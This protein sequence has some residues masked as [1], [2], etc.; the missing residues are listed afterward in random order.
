MG[1]L[2]TLAQ[3]YIMT[4]TNQNL[5][6]PEH[7][8]SE[9]EALKAE[10]KTIRSEKPKPLFVLEKKTQIL[11]ITKTNQRFRL[12]P[13]NGLHFLLEEQFPFNV[14]EIPDQLNYLLEDFTDLAIGVMNTDDLKR[15]RKMIQGLRF[16]M[17][18]TFHKIYQK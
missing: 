1:L 13:Q 3:F 6:S 8:S 4:P 17:G 5:R 16:F 12:M 15:Y 11:K 9:I 18:E 14:E 10:L 7:I 2:A